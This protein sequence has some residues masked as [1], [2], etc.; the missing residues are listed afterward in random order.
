M[1][2]FITKIKWRKG[3][4]CLLGVLLVML[5]FGVFPFR[6]VIDKVDSALG[7]WIIRNS[8]GPA[9]KKELVLLGIDEAS[10]ALDSLDPDEIASNPTLSLMND[11]FPWDR[12]V[13]AEA[14]DRLAGAGAKLIVFDLIFT[15]ASDP[16]ADAAFAAEIKRHTG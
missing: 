4:A 1:S 12:R 15:S 9:E 7:V 8:G 2:K 5:G 16:E 10:M 3:L 13:W 11:R 14:I 6:P